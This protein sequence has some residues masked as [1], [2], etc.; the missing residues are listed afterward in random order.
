MLPGVWATRA[1]KY[2][3]AFLDEA[4]RLFQDVDVLIAPAT[5]CRAP[6][7]GQ[8]TFMLDGREQLV[9]PNIGVFTQPISFIGLPVVAAPLWTAGE[10]LPI[11][12]QII[13]AP[14][15]ED[16]ALRVARQLERDGVAA[17]PMAGT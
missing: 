4:L 14:W 16:L 3:R 11:G 17:A 15:R 10:R 7:I 12:V 9:R 1:Q 5:P 2:R 8:K 6:A 13:A